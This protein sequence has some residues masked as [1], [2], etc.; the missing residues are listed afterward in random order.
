MG[1]AIHYPL[2]HEVL[3]SQPQNRII[4]RRGVGDFYGTLEILTSKPAFFS[5]LG[6][7]PIPTFL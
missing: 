4:S 6:Q 2:N 7:S 1:V 3:S 5:G